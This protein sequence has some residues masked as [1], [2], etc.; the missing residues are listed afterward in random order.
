MARV[1]SANQIINDTAIEVGLIPVQDPYGSIDE[2]FIQLRGLLQGAGREMVDLHAWQMLRNVFEFTTDE[3]ST[4]TRPLPDDF[5]R[6]INQ[7]GWDRTN[8]VA[9]GGPLS[10]QDWSYLDGRDLVSESIYASFRIADGMLDL[11][12]TPPPIG[13]NI[14]FEYISRNW[15]QEAAGD[16]VVRKDRIGKGTD[17]VLFEPIMMVKFLKMKFLS[18]KGFDT[19]SATQEFENMFGA[20]TGMDEGAPILSAGNNGRA[21]PYIDTLRNTPDS[22]YGR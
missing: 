14:R 15:V 2:S 7:T 17:I 3:N 22:G 11:Y 4:G 8:N 9:M 1:E 10:A 19:M 20:R 5:S 13:L 18:A 12:P 6:M 21:F 16:P